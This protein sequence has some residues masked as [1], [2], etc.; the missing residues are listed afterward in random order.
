MI[1][2]WIVFAVLVAFFAYR[3]YRQGIWVAATRIVSLALA[4]A[5]A[6]W[7]S[8][9]L[10]PVIEERTVIQG[11]AAYVTAGLSLFFLTSTFL[12][13]LFSLLGKLFKGDKPSALSAGLG[14]VMGVGIGAVMGLAVVFCISYM[15]ELLNKQGPGREL[16][17]IEQ[18][19]RSAAAHVSTW[20]A[21]AADMDPLSTQVGSALMREPG[22]VVE[23]VKNLQNDNQ[24]RDLFNDPA[25]Q[26]VFQSGD[27]DAIRALPAF[28]TFA[29]NPE[30]EALLDVAGVENNAETQA[31]LASQTG[32]IWQRAQALQHDAEM[33]QLLSDPELRRALNDGN[34]MVVLNNAKFMRVVK[35]FLNEQDNPPLATQ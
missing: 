4:Y 22:K 31:L 10:A 13:L 9:S 19:A 11:L 5:V 35:L 30:M 26:T 29:N 20:V 15:A 17:A 2:T 8:G 27:A 3:G 12:S 6:L 25:N 24:V 33:Q 23:H 34:P 21:Q 1:I 7:Y 18:L 32:R 16:T 28:Q 14:S